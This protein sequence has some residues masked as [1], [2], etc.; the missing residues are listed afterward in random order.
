M[1]PPSPRQLRLTSRV[2]RHVAARPADCRQPGPAPSADTPGHHV[3]ELLIPGRR[4]R[5]LRRRRPGVGGAGASLEPCPHRGPPAALRRGERHPGRHRGPAPRPVA[6]RGGAA[7]GAAPADPG[8]LNCR[9]AGCSCYLRPPWSTSSWP[10]VARRPRARGP[11]LGTHRRPSLSIAIVEPEGPAVIR[12]RDTA[13]SCLFRWR[14]VPVELPCVDTRLLEGHG[15]W[16]AA[17]LR[18]WPPAGVSACSSPS[19]HRST[20][21]AT[22]WWPDSS[23]APR[24]RNGRPGP[25]PCPTRRR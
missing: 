10:A 25:R 22:K 3:L 13:L 7:V 16:I 20:A 11:L 21:T 4:R 9:P 5:P 1:H 6:T 14:G 18:R 23:P 19:P 8:R 15:P 17:G 12:L 24:G 2:L